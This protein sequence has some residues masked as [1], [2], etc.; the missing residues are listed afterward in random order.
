MSPELRAMLVA[1]YAAEKHSASKPTDARGFALAVLL[2][3][4]AEAAQ[5]RWFKSVEHT[6]PNLVALDG[7]AE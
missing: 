7:G 2:E 4:H 3:K 6:G 5:L 1:I